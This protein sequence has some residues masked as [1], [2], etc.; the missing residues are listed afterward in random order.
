MPVRCHA[1]HDGQGIVLSKI[2]CAEDAVSLRCF[3]ADRGAT[4]VAAEPAGAND[5]R[6]RLVGVSVA[7]LGRLIAASNI[8]LIA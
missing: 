2:R 1:E 8:E 7:E 5:Y 6:L 3:F 4:A